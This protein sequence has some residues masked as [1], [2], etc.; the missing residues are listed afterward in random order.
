[1]ITAIVGI[2][3]RGDLGAVAVTIIIRVGIQG[4][5]EVGVDL[6][7]VGQAVI[8]SI[9]VLRIGAV[10]IFQVVRQAVA[11]VVG[12]TRLGQVPEV[13]IS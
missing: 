6:G 8:V 10:V 5:G 9:V 1:M 11:V 12:R 7:A 13:Q 3:T 2:R 4:I